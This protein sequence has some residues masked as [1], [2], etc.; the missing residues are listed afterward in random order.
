[1]SRTRLPDRR[2]AVTQRVVFTTNSGREIN[3]IV[4]FGTDADD[5]GKEVFCDD[6]KVGSENQAIVMD[7]CILLSRL[8]QHGETPQELADTMCS[9]PSLI[10]A[11]ARAMAQE[12]S[13]GR[14]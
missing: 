4:S 5:A 12:H 3:V 13:N 14:S 10:G 11:I 2:P 1:M 7:A 8:L 6:L 9:P